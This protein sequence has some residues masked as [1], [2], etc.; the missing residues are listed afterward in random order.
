[1]AGEVLFAE[2]DET[3][4]LIMLLDGEVQIVG[5]ASRPADTVIVTYGTGQFLGEIG[6]LTGQRVYLAAIART[7]GRILRVPVAQVR[8]VMAQELGLSELILRTFLIRHANLTRLG[9]GLTLIVSRF[10]AET[11]RILEVLARNRLPS[12]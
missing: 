10:D 12:R 2:G 5:N 7:A 3:Y 4:D 1:M 6:L 11:R 9:S 8:E